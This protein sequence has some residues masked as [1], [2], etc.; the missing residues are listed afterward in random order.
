MAQSRG[1]LL[2]LTHYISCHTTAMQWRDNR[3]ASTW[4]S[5]QVQVRRWQSAASLAWSDSD[6]LDVTYFLNATIYHFKQNEAR[7]SSTSRAVNA[8][9]SI[10]IRPALRRRLSGV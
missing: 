8:P 1:K 3:S 9:V 2:S 4:S 7:V 10:L 6:I 5:L